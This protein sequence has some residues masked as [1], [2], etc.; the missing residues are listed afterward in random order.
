MRKERTRVRGI[1]TLG[2]HVWLPCE[3]QTKMPRRVWVT[4][5]YY[6]SHGRRRHVV[7]FFSTSIICVLLLKIM[8]TRP[9]GRQSACSRMFSLAGCSVLDGGLLGSVRTRATRRKTLS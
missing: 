8:K 4:C 6:R 3:G 1:Y 2:E 9:A 7:S 5:R